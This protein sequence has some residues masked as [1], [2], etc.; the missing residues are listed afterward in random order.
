MKIASK[1]ALVLGSV[2]GIGKAIGLNLAHAGAKVVYTHYDWPE[3]LASL[4]QEAEATGQDHWIAKVNLLDTHDI[5]LLIK[6]IINRFGRRDIL[7]NNTDRAGS[8]L[9]HGL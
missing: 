1:V 9:L 3:S 4:Q 2:K 5:E 7:F 8:P 6:E